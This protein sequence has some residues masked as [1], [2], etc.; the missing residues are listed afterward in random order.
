LGLAIVKAIATAHGGTVSAEE[1]PA[2]GA[3]IQLD[4]P[5]EPLET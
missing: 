3:A 1:S 2:G 5:M 4:L